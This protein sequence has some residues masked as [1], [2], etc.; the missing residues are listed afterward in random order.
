MNAL[1]SHPH[2][3]LKTEAI[4]GITTFLTMAY[5]V[6]VNP[7]ILSTE[8]TGMPFAGVLTATVLVC[9][10]STLAMGL[11]AN[12]P[13]G[14]APGM[15]LNAFFTFTVVLQGAV[16]W[17]IA[18]GMVF[19]A[20]VLF[21]LTSVTPLREAIANAIPPSLRRATAAGIG[22]L[23]T[24]IGLQNAGF[25]AANPATLV[26]VGPLDHR[27]LLTVLGIGIIV[28]LTR[29]GS[30]FAFLAAIVAVTAIAWTAG[31][32]TPPASWFSPP[33]FT[34]VFLQ[35]DVMGALQ[36][37]LLPAIVTLMMTDMFDSLS[38]FV[39]VAHASGMLDE[40]GRPHNLRKGLIVDA[41]ATLG[42]AL[43]GSSPGTAYVES[44]AG[45]R[46][47]GRSGRTAVVTA[48]CFVPCL[49]IAPVAAAVPSYATAAVLIVVGVSMFHVVT[50]VDFARLE[51][52]VPAFATLILIPLTFS[53][54]QG[55]L[56]GFILHGAL[57]VVAGR[58]RELSRAVVA[59]A[60]VSMAL[61]V[62]EHTR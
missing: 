57:F 26:G 39:G 9:V 36:L 21:L 2:P 30:P 15:G 7:T 56:W 20:G 17:P 52:A 25:V 45:V 40:D 4:A 11:Y 42:A 32:V 48:L 47:G 14:V 59:L 60:L 33:D 38:T 50:D 43:V 28:W 6:I 29:R 58:R 44:I 35:L 22:L 24:F 10:A 37:A 62:L 23:L 3:A 54:T 41:W 61:L 13:F 1:D 27:T 8:G 19:W 12:L 55:I 34:S 53:I 49:F 18:L 51:V 16:P 5:I 46:A 31:W